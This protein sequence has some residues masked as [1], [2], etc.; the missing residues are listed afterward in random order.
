MKPRVH[1]GQK[2]DAGGQ[3]T[4]GRIIS[5]ATR[6]FAENGYDGTSIKQISEQAGVNIAA[7]NYHFASKENLFRRIIEQF[8]SDLFVSS[9]K[10]LTPPQNAED[11]KV[12][13]E[14]FV[15]QTIE[16]IIR[17]P[18]VTTI[19]QR[20]GVRSAEIFKKTI[21]QH[22]AALN[23]F[24][25]HART[26]GLLAADVDPEFAAAFLMAQ[27]AQGTRKDRAKREFFGQTPASERCRNQWIRQTIRLFCGGIL[28]A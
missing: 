17:Q 6:L 23:A 7:V 4:A 24:L 16:A 8:L 14:I 10:T 15:R 1:G 22:R 2:T 19:I 25:E 20:E 21:L 13:L 9:R 28:A 26:I 3:D 18:D 12:R 27:I 11:M 5:M